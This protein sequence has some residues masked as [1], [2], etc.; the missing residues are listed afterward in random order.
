MTVIRPPELDLA[1]IR[2]AVE[3]AYEDWDGVKWPKGL[4]SKIRNMQ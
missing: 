3:G 4:L 1:A 2:K